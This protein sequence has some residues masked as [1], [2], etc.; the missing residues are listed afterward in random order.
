MACI[1]ADGSLT[2]IAQKVL[3]AIL[4]PATASEIQQRAGIPLYRVRASL[5]ELMELNM[6]VQQED[7]YHITALG[8][9]RLEQ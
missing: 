4:E 1:N 3:R 8:Q 2:P 6:V 9:A 5:R 7:R